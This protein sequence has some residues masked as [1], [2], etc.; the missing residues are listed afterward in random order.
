[1]MWETLKT[2]EAGVIVHHPP[3]AGALDSAL[4]PPIHPL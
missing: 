3:V 1:M 4:C 2:D